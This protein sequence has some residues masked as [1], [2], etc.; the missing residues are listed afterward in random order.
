M[1][2]FFALLA[3][4]A[5]P[6]RKM[7]DIFSNVQAGFAACDRIFARLDR[8]PTVRDP[9]QPAPS[10]GTIASCRSRT[11]VSPISPTSRCWKT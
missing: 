3:G 9:K 2:T 5:D 1:L 4:M 6:L 11:S 10:S 7:S 8:E